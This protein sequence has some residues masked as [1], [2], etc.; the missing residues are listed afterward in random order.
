MLPTNNCGNTTRI[1]HRPICR[2]VIPEA[3][4]LLLVDSTILRARKRRE[5]VNAASS[6]DI[7]HQC[8]ISPSLGLWLIL[9]SR[10]GLFRRPQI[11]ISWWVGQIRVGDMVRA[12]WFCVRPSSLGLGELLRNPSGLLRRRMVAHREPNWKRRQPGE[13]N[14]IVF[15]GSFS[16]TNHPRY[17]PAVRDVYRLSHAAPLDPDLSR[18][19]RNRQRGEKVERQMAFIRRTGWNHQRWSGCAM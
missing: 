10:L 19:R 6:A 16:Q 13:I 14:S 8:V 7:V 3:G 4:N 18:L 12:I 11:R 5:L 1:G 15:L 2:V 9:E 17:N